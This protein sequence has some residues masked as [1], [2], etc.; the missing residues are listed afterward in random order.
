MYLQNI[1][2]HTSE[3][4]NNYKDQSEEHHEKKNQTMQKYKFRSYWIANI[5]III[6]II[7]LAFLLL[8]LVVSVF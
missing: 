4:Y 1:P 6:G 3:D 8:K 2:L 5:L 7:P